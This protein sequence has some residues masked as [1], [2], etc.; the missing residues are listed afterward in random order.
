M[1]VIAESFLRDIF[2][3]GI[4]KTFTVEEGQIVTPSAVQLFSEKGVELVMGKNEAVRN[5]PV[6]ENKTPQSSAGLR[7]VSASDG[8]VHETKPEYM[9]QL[10][11]RVLV[12]K[13]HP[14]IF[15]RGKLDSLQSKILVRQRRSHENKNEK[16]VKDL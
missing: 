3:K 16:L 4:P 8:G 11:G 14:R 9:T 10:H 7:Y 1:K 5:A 6:K 12:P 2:R 15:F 13:D